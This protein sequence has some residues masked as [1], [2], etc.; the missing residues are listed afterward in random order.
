[1]IRLVDIQKALDIDP[2]VKL[3]GSNINSH[4]ADQVSKGNRSYLS[5]ADVWVAPRGNI[6]DIDELN[7]SLENLL[8][9]FEP[10]ELIKFEEKNGI[11]QMG[12]IEYFEPFWIQTMTIKTTDEVFN[13]EVYEQ[14]A[15]KGEDFVQKDIFEYGLGIRVRM[16]PH[17]AMMW[18]EMIRDDHTVP[19]SYFREFK[20][21]F[22]PRILN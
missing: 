15:R 22:G 9:E 2:D 20:G 19:I 21:E 18:N 13:R 8:P 11:F 4:A 5:H 7:E 10:E 1:M 17:Q 6:F 16:I 3:F 14:Y 12:M